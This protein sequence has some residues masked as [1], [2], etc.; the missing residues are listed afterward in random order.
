MTDHLELGRE[1]E[2]IAAA[3]MQKSGCR[4]LERNVRFGR[5]ELDLIVWDVPRK[6]VVFVEVKTRTQTSSA[7]PASSAVDKHK[8]RCLK[9]AV[10]GWIIRHQYRGPGRTDIVCVSGNRITQHIMNIG[11]DFF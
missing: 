5:D 2:D 4:I 11:S 6:M 7:Y 8:R 9:R 10:N 1:G 3:Y